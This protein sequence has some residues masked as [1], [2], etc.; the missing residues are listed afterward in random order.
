MLK[1]DPESYIDE[2]IGQLKALVER[3]QEALKAEVDRRTRLVLNEL[4]EFADMCKENI[5]ADAPFDELRVI[6]DLG[7]RKKRVEEWVGEL[8]GEKFKV[9][10]L[11][12]ILRECE[13]ETRELREKMATIK[14]LFIY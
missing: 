14:R 10:Y 11:L 12:M 4:G 7:M 8:R 1:N 2:Q 13:N 9:N 6:G 5:F 3:K